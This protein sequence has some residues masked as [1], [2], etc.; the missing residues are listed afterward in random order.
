MCL[1]KVYVIMDCCVWDD[2]EYTKIVGV[3]TTKEFAKDILKRY[4]K[5]VKKELDFDNLDLSENGIDDGYVVEADDDYFKI[6]LNGEYNSFHTS[7]SIVE[8]ELISEKEK[9]NGYGF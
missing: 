9:E 1:D 8:K 2:E 4:V 5:D 6:Y 3:A 7:I